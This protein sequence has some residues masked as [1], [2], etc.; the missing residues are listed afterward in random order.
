SQTCKYPRDAHCLCQPPLQEQQRD[1]QVRPV[2]Q[3]KQWQGQQDSQARQ[4]DQDRQP[5]QQQE[6]QW[7]PL[8]RQAAQQDPQSRAPEQADQQ[9]Q[10][11]TGAPQAPA[12]PRQNG[13]WQELERP[14][15]NQQRQAQP[16]QQQQQQQAPTAQARQTQPQQQPGADPQQDAMVERVWNI[17]SLGPREE[18]VI[19]VSGVPTR[20]GDFQTCVFANYER[21]LCT[22]MQITRPDLQL[23]R[24]WV[25]EQ[26]T[27]KQSLFVCDP[28]FIHYTI[29]NPGTGSTPQTVIT[30]ELP[31][32]I[33]TNDGNNVVTVNV[34]ELQAGQ[35]QTFA[36]PVIATQPGEFTGRATARA[37][38]P[39]TT[40]SNAGTI[41]LAYAEIDVQVQGRATQ[42][43]DRDV[44]YRITVRN[45]SDEVP[46]LNTQV[47]VPGIDRRMRFA[48]T[49]QQIPAQVNTFTIGTLAPGES[50][51]FGIAF[52]GDRAGE[53]ATQVVA[54]AYCAENAVANISTEFVGIP[55]LQIVV[56]DRVDPV[57]VGDTTVYDISVVNEGTTA[58]TN[59]VFSGELP[60]TLEFINARG[61]SEVFG[62]QR[63]LEF[64]PIQNLRPGESATWQVTVRGVQPGQGEFRLNVQSEGGTFTGA[65]PTTVY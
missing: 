10:V 15:A 62:D 32:G 26:R 34:G 60:P 3:D 21:A 25:D 7:Q 13:E 53:I 12:P 42:Y 30:E 37:G 28:L 6:A 51:S 47:H 55:A 56:V 43:I 54:M 22:T 24:R 52:S 14:Q 59:I 40:Q 63:T 19:R 45:L 8:D 35:V 48:A 29:S 58:E 9:R 1:Q 38:N 17:G 16:Q 20:E 61:D 27:E 57:A 64:A 4:Q 41:R 23:S 50:R 33:T 11:A 44:E 2:Q 46:A 39:L 36:V 31:Q 18:R 5:Q 65:E 49:D